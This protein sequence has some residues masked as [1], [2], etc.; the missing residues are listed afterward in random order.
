MFPPPFPG[1]FPPPYFPQQG[2]P[3][4]PP[5]PGMPGGG[6]QYINIDPKSVS[7]EDLDN[8]T[9]FRKTKLCSQ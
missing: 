9:L 6:P 5:M 2:M 4:M 7:D 3:G 1:G 8:P